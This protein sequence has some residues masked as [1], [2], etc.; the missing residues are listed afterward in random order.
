[1][2]LNKSMNI[3][4]GEKLHKELDKYCS[5]H[6]TSIYELSEELGFTRTFFRDCTRRNRI[7]NVGVNYLTAKGILFDDYKIIEEVE[8]VEEPKTNDDITAKL[9]EILTAI[10]KLGN[11]Q[12]QQL[13]Y[14][15]EVR[16]ALK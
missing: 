4:D 11:I 15:K 6:N 10:N 9:D 7:N 2:G 5:K 16:D 14:L 13:E 1:M 3:I 12:M 8:Q